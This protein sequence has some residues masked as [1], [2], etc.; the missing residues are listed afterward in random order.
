MTRIAEITDGTSNTIAIGEDAGRDPRYLSPYNEGY[1]NNVITRQ[2]AMAITNPNDPGPAG[3]YA[4]IVATGAGPS[5]TVAMASPAVPITNTDPITSPPYGGR[6]PHT[7]PRATTPAITTRSP[8]STPVARTS[9]SAMAAS[10]SSRTRSTPS[11]CAAWSP[12]MA[13]KSSRPISID[14][15]AGSRL[16]SIPDSRVGRGFSESRTRGHA[17]RHGPFVCASAHF[18]MDVG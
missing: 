1:Y 7:S 3:G 16:S 8:R 18:E 17:A 13:A 4:P 15:L 6:A 10:G 2:A 12:S 5:P 9:Y 11:P 14:P